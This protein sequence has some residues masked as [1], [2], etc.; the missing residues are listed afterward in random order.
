M[1]GRMRGV[2]VFG[3]RIQVGRLGANPQ[4]STSG[5]VGKLV[6]EGFRKE[7][8]LQRRTMGGDP[9][10]SQRWKVGCNGERWVETRDD[11]RNGRWVGTGGPPVPTHFPSLRW[12]SVPTSLSLRQPHGPGSDGRGSTSYPIYRYRRRRRGGR[13]PAR[14]PRGRRSRR[15]RRALRAGRSRAA[16]TAAPPRG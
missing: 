2:C 11:R 8:T 5:R 12:P 13:A 7:R 9:R 16:R 4:H 6:L 14:C 15:A 1:C 10:R 3:P